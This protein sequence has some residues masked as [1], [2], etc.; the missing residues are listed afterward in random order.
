MIPYD[1]LVAALASW[2]SRQGLPTGLIAGGASPGQAPPGAA[3]A[4][5]TAAGRSGPT[6]APPG[7]AA[8]PGSSRAAPGAARP[9]AVV[10]DATHEDSL[11]V[12]EA[13]LLEESSFD[14]DFGVTF[15]AGEVG[16]STAIG[17]AP[18]P[19]SADVESDD[20]RPRPPPP[21]RGGR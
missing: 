2:R 18:S 10:I 16:E 11:D 1:D 5:G 14:S 19:R 12:D 21:R 8:A 3:A 4:P 20:V 7:A 17:V 13:A 9:A 15:D 6:A